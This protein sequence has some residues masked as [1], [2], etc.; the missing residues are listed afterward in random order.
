M[1]L[2]REQSLRISSLLI[3]TLP[4][5]TRSLLQ[6]VPFDFHFSGTRVWEH[7]SCLLYVSD[8]ISSEKVNHVVSLT[9]FKAMKNPDGSSYLKWCFFEQMVT[10]M[11]CYPWGFTVLVLFNKIHHPETSKV[12]QWV[13]KSM[14]TA[15]KHFHLFYIHVFFPIDQLGALN[16]WSSG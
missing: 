3:S 11:P 4:F 14:K 1:K 9:P 8:I 12:H 6:S 16:T 13:F 15:P 5:T 2:P 10:Q 7:V